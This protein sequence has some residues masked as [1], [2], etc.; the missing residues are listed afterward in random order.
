[1]SSAS[2]VCS[3]I[4]AAPDSRRAPSASS[5]APMPAGRAGAG[6]AADRHA[7]PPRPVR[8]PTRSS[9]CSSTATVVGSAPFCGP[10]TARGAHRPEQRM[11]DVG[12]GDQ[13][14]PCQ[15]A[16]GACAS[17]PSASTSPRPPSV[18]PLPPRPT[19]ILPRPGR[20]A[21]SM[22][23]PTPRLCAA[24][25]V[26]HGRRAAEQR[27][28]AGL[29]ALDVGGRGSRSNT[30]SASTSS[31][32]GPDTRLC[33]RSPSRLASTPTK[34]GPPSDCG[35]RRELVAGPGPLPARRDRLAR[36]RPRSGCRRSS[37]GRSARAG[38]VRQP[39]TPSS[40]QGK[41]GTSSEVHAWQHR[42]AAAK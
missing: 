22:S 42:I 2:P 13:L 15:R 28:P 23:W 29:R 25:A 31:A 14:D 19:T 12:G 34:P 35:A 30:H 33:R 32:S 38:H 37:P 18:Q 20:N 8:P 9:C 5:A 24:T 10:K 26:A 1:M 39:A 36:P 40:Q 41:A 16:P 4:T 7:R 3:A 11:L 21:A 6:P 17:P 27:Q